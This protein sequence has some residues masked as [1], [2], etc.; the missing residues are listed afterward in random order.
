LYIIEEGL[1]IFFLE[2]N[3][4]SKT[5]NVTEESCKIILKIINIKLEA[6][7][8]IEASVKNLI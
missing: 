4:I 1:L 5:I 6:Q 3:C 7:P 2:L 8:G